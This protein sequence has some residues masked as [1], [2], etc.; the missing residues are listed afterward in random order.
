MSHE[1]VQI[2]LN[3]K[4]AKT[5]NNQN[6][7]DIDFETNLIQVD[8]RYSIHL[9]VIN[10]SIPYSFY[11]INSTN[12]KLNYQE[13]TTP[14]PTGLTLYINYGNY[15][16]YQLATYLS[17]NLPNTTVTYNSIINKFTFS[18]S[19]NDF[20][21]LSQFSTCINVLGLSTNDLYNSSIGKNLTLFK[22]VN[23]AQNQMIKIATNFQS[24][25]ISNLNNNDM[26]ILCSF[27]VSNSPYSLIT[28]TN[29]DKYKIDLN[30]NTFNTINIKL[31]NQDEEPL[32]LNQQ[33]FSLTLQL[34]FVNFV[35]Y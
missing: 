18:N 3:S 33:Y 14:D 32:E 17:Q 21:I 6:Y 5:F 8:D 4:F 34:D 35:G 9:S 11:N 25:S 19:V 7:S 2:H 15:T 13:L 10:A 26:K 27:P 1:S 16:A 20:K 23:L 30:K 12:N 24:G 31:L 29:N 28:Y 22:Q